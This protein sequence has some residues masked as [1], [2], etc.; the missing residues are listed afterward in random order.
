MQKKEL[1]KNILTTVAYYD[2]MDYPLTSFEIW[3]YLT[4]LDSTQDS[5][6]R[7]F[8]LGDVIEMLRNEN[9]RMALE[10]Y[11]GFFIL[12][13]RK[14]IVDR[15]IRNGKI[16]ISKLKKLRRVVWALRFV[17]FVRMIGVTG[18][19]AMKNAREESDWDLF[20]VIKSGRIWTGR[21]LVTALVHIL[22]KRRHGDKISD[23]V[24]LNYFITDQ[25]LEIST[26]D[27][28][29]AS[30]YFFLLPLFDTGG[31]FHQFQM[32]NSW[33]K[34]FKPNYHLAETDN[35][36][37]LKD[38][39]FS[40]LAR[41]FREKLISWDFLENWLRKWQKKRIFNNPKTCQKGSFIQA[42]DERLVFLPQPQGPRIFEKFREK[43]QNFQ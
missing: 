33:I 28:F 40:R 2:A 14:E 10:E 27:L 21:T 41:N 31:V 7:T 18:G 30:E 35:L 23:R 25:S 43:M 1:Q 22:G 29:S 8:S 5:N 32:K 39:V 6:S 19:L 11:K 36:K 24:C 26:K 34:D 3:K 12:R 38:S 15:R 16:S 42:E 13:G 37:I 17:P 4:S 20:I 9:M